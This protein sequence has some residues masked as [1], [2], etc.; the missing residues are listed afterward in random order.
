MAIRKSVSQGHTL[1]NNTG[2]V[3]TLKEAEKMFEDSKIMKGVE[4]RLKKKRDRTTKDPEEIP[5]LVNPED[6][7]D[8][9]NPT[10]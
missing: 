5:K 10:G 3:G 1:V 7:I 9:L 2:F 8:Q 4:E 6:E